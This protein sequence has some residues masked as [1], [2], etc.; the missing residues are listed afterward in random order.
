[1]ELEKRIRILERQ[2][3]WMKLIFLAAAVI[4]GVAIFAGAGDQDNADSTRVADL[5]RAKRFEVIG[6]NNKVVGILAARGKTADLEL[7]DGNS[8]TYFEAHG[9]DDKDGGGTI[10]LYAPRGFLNVARNGED[11]IA[12]GS[13]P[14][15]SMTISES[16]GARFYL[17]DRKGD[18]KFEAVAP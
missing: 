4:G 11:G 9:Y 2:N 13:G 17:N 16:E 7:K 6:E 10:Y 1:M 14:R 12:F 15:A 3:S 18:R 5:V 8:K